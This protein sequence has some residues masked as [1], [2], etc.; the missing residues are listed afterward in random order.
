MFFRKKK[1]QAVVENPT[2]TVTGTRVNSRH[3]FPL[4][5]KL[6][7]AQAKE[8]G[9]GPKEVAVLIGASPYTV[10]KWHKL[11]MKGGP[12]ALMSQSSSPKTRRICRELEQRIELYRTDNPSA[13]VRRIRDILKREQGL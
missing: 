12:E 4:E 13:G 10:S 3:R 2:P 6:L 11:Y 5:I 1:K 9:L 7:A 8:A